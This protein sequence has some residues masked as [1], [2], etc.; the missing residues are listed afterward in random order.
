MRL[1]LLAAVGAA[2]YYVVTRCAPDPRTW[3]SQAQEDLARL[4]TN[5][6]EAVAAGKRAAAR[7]EREMLDELGTPAE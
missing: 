5:L 3:P 6:A 4:K 7:R 2:A 1:V